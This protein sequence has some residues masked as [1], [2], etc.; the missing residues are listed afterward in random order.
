MKK[1]LVLLTLLAVGLCGEINSA[2]AAGFRRGSG[3]SEGDF[4]L[5]K[6][7]V[8]FEALDADPTTPRA[9]HM[10]LYL[11]DDAG[12]L[13][14]YTKDPAGTVTALG[15]GGGGG[16]SIIFDIGDDGG[17]DSTAL[18]EIATTNDTNAIFTEVSA[19]KL[20]IDL[21]KNW[22]KAD[23]VKDADFGDITV[24][25]GAWNLDTD[26]V[27]ANELNGAGVESEMEGLIDLQDLQ[28]TVTDAQ[29]PNTITIDL[30][31]LATT[32]TTANAG[33]SA[34]AF[35]P[36]G[37]IEHER[38]GLEADINA[39]DG[40]I[41]IT[42]GATYNL[43]GTT[44]QIPIFD[45]AGAPTV[46]ALSGD[47]TMTNAGVVTIGAD[48]VALTTDTTGNYAAG[49]AEAGAALTGDSATSFFVAGTLENARLDSDIEAIGNN[50][51]SG[52]LTRTGS[53]TVSARTI[54]AG[55]N[56][57]VTNGDGV[58]GNPTIA[59]AVGATTLAVARRPT[60]SWSATSSARAARPTS[61][62]RRKRT[63]PPTRKSSAS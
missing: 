63:R 53:G 54:T 20:L 52:L 60:V 39:Y 44:T 50:S 14:L 46:A 57:T 40:L 47:V 23:N 48:K 27:S 19:D 26:S 59:A 17:N 24:S 29:V 41:G 6:Y 2:S 21:S 33:D 34:T 32:A 1:A 10:N 7:S 35:F 51:T 25:S 30:A 37:T 38:G 36:A 28:G 55:T 3:F 56:I 12:T 49:D 13:K 42:G 9:N 31:T 4:L 62:R 16:S 43:T 11:K 61:T 45:G 22:P 58:S 5:D 15:A 18:G 8:I